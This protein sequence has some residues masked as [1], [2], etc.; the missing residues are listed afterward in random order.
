MEGIRAFNASL[1]IESIDYNAQCVYLIRSVDDFKEEYL[2]G[3]KYT[4]YYLYESL[5][6][7]DFPKGMIM[8]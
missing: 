7:E 5:N 4:Y 8:K 2:D 6:E 3:D 1:S